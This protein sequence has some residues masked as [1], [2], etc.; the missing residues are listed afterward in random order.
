MDKKL[1][2]V[3]YQGRIL[4]ALMENGRAAELH[5]DE[6]Q[7]NSLLGN[8]YIGKV[9]N[10][11]KNIR[12]AFIEI[13]NGIQCYYSLSDNK[14]PIYI[15]KGSSKD[16]QAGDE[17]LVQVCRENLKSKPPAVSSNLNFTGNYLVLTTGTNPPACPPSLPR[18]RRNG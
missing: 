12:A 16:M 18:K 17:L 8:I 14:D 2:I 11:V 6:E 7:R 13:E 3:R 15:K 9:K 1:I 4:T 5:C 10:I